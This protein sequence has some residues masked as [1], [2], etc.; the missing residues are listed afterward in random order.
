MPRVRGGE[1]ENVSTEG[2]TEA[3]LRAAIDRLGWYVQH[4]PG[5]PS[6]AHPADRIIR[7]VERH[8]EPEYEP[9]GAY[10]D[11]RGDNY[12]RSSIGDWVDRSGTR[13]VGAF[14]ARP[15]RKLVP[16]SRTAMVL[17]TKL[18]AIRDLCEDGELL[19]ARQVL[20]IIDGEGT[21]P[22]GC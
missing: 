8:R 10:V 14:P 12:L 3:E 11:A 7:D 4:E 17:A 19:P 20:A 16:E 2:I 18:N 15:L 1:D 5:I 9:G 6:S 22:G 13:H 21:C